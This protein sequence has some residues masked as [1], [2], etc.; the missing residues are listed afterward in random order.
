MGGLG[1]LVVHDGYHELTLYRRVQ[2][3]FNKAKAI[4]S[5]SHKS[6]HF[7]YALSTRI[8]VA[9]DTRWSSH[10]RLH[11]H[12]P[13]NMEDINRVLA[14]EKINQPALIFSRSDREHL[15]LVV[16]VMQYFA[17]ATD[18]LQGKKCL[19]VIESFQ[20]LIH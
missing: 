1:V 3:A 9:N 4:C 2:A 15:S 20:L 18:I 16:D 8:P 5:L 19:L 14:L 7:A 11:E 13:E 17:Q 12:L 6:S 10:F